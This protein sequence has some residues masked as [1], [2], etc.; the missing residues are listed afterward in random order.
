MHAMLTP[1]F[2]KFQSI[3]SGI[4]LFTLTFDQKAIHILEFDKRLAF[5]I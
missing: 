5:K 4:L 1:H 2:L 3:Y